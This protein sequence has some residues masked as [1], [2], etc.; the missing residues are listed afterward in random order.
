MEYAQQKMNDEEKDTKG[1]NLK[2]GDIEKTIR[3]LQREVEIK[4]KKLQ[5]LKKL[6]N[7]KLSAKMI[8]ILHYNRNDNFFFSYSGKK[9]MSIIRKFL[10]VFIYLFIYKIFSLIYFS[11]LNDEMFT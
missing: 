6:R 4:E 3:N 5:A 2:V 8:K 7:M 9:K 10:I 1:N 11:D